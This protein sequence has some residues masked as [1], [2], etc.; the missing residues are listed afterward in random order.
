L[1]HVIVVSGGRGWIAVN[2]VI[3][4]QF[5]PKSQLEAAAAAV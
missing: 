2:V 5:H 3:V 1:L 4:N